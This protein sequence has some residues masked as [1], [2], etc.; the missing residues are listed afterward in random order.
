MTVDDDTGRPWVFLPQD[1][2]LEK[3]MT[4]IRKL[5]APFSLSQVFGS[6]LS[7]LEPDMTEAIEE[8]LPTKSDPA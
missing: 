5:R 6:N 1:F 2:F 7:P 8:A 4:Q 3:K